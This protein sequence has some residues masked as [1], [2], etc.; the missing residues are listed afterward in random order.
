LYKSCGSGLFAFFSR[1]GFLLFE[2]VQAFKNF[3]RFLRRVAVGMDDALYHPVRGSYAGRYDRQGVYKRF[4]VNP[5]GRGGGSSWR[6]VR[7]S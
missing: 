7:R 5:K 6:I 2:E 1:G 3:D 4:H